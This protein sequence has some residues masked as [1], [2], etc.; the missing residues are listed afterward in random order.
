MGATRPPHGPDRRPADRRPGA[1]RRRAL[2]RRLAGHAFALVL[3]SPLS[4][5]AE[6]AAL[7]GFGD[8]AIRDPDLREWDYGASRAG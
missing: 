8:A 4:R 7:A 2:G 5:A 3:T 1:S 6:T